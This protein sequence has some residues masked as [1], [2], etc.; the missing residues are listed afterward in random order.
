MN[1]T[2]TKSAS[3]DPKTN[4]DFKEDV[5]VLQEL[6]DINADAIEFYTTASAKASAR[7]IVDKFTSLKQL[8]QDSEKA[9]QLQLKKVASKLNSKV[10]TET[11]TTL[12]GSTRKWFSEIAAKFSGNGDKILVDQLEKAE[13]RCLKTI[14]NAVKNPNVSWNTQELLQDQYNKLKRTHHTM[15][16]LKQA[17]AA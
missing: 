15:Q 14:Q 4:V 3:S 10:R 13:D 2:T 1:T 5:K 8:H 6:C 17:M 11:K 16:D 9:M 12:S 7:N